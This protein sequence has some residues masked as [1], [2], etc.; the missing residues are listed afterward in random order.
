MSQ[1]MQ[2]QVRDMARN[3]SNEIIRPMAQELDETENF[4]HELYLNMGELGCLVL[5]YL[6][7]TVGLGLILLLMHW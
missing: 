4:P 7:K 1:E 3:F 5:A 2:L 6:R